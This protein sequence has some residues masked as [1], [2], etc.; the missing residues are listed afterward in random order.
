MLS[1]DVLDL[2]STSEQTSDAYFVSEYV[3]DLIRDYLYFRGYSATLKALENDQKN[4][5]DKILQ[6]LKIIREIQLLIDAHDLMGLRDYWGYL[7]KQFFSR[8]EKD[9]LE[10]MRKIETGILRLY[11][12][13]AIREGKK[14]KVSKGISQFLSLLRLGLS[15]QI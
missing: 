5:R 14:D 9:H 12:T 4:S 6:P 7:H 13:S 3:E 2:M 11:L 1:A 15:V 10:V 8:L